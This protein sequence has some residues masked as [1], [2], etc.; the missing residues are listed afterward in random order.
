MRFVDR[1][2]PKTHSK[3]FK[4]EGYVNCFLGLLRRCAI[5][6]SF[7]RFKAF[8]RHYR[9]WTFVTAC[10]YFFFFASQVKVATLWKETSVN[11]KSS[12]RM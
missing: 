7:M 9:A 12:K 8:E 6:Q 1:L 2:N 3:P 5:C 10:D 11:L 4:S